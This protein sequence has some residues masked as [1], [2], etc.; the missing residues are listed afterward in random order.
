MHARISS[1]LSESLSLPCYV[2]LIGLSD[3]PD[4]LAQHR[5]RHYGYMKEL[6]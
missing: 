6:L 1:A 3:A 5:Y 2:N 4:V